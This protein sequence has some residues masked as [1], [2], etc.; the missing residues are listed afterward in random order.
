MSNIDETDTFKDIFEQ[1]ES[2]MEHMVLF[3][4]QIGLIQ[5][6]FKGLEKNVRKQ[7][8]S[9]KKVSLKNKNKGNRK[10]SGFAKPTRVTKELCDFM[11]KDEG[12]EIART[13][14]TRALISYIDLNNL[15]NETN[16]KVISPDE[17]LKDLLGINEDQEL[18]YFNLQK[19][20][21]K[22]FIS[23]KS[24]SNESNS[25]TMEEM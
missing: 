2:I 9:L 6:Q 23:L 8:N 12:S 14:V 10:P 3:K 20:M 15:Q 1:F 11:N 21:N 13:E 24:N 19:Y 7:M 5:T 25:K 17:K 4:S 18:T 16:K 22:H